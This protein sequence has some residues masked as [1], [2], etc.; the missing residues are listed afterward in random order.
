MIFI[1][2][3]CSQEQVERLGYALGYSLALEATYKGSI[4]DLHY[5]TV[6]NCDRP[7]Y[8]YR[9]ANYNRLNCR[10]YD[11]FSAY[12]VETTYKLSTLDIYYAD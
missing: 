2:T 10:Y 4:D 11:I 5:Y 1:L 3:A 8:S 9:D 6:N 7:L 12:V